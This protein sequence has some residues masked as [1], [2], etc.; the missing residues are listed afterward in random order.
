MSKWLIHGSFVLGVAAL[1]PP[2]LAQ[3]T[4]APREALIKQLDG[5][6]KETLTGGGLRNDNQVLEIW[7]A[8]ET[9]TWTALLTSANGLSCILATGTH[10]YQHQPELPVNDIPS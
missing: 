6:Y 4:C 10:W 1:T 7:T 8:P 9:G 5:K 3:S 2:A